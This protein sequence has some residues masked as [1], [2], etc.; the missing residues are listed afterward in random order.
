MI[1]QLLQYVYT[2]PISVY[3]WLVSVS[4]E[5][6]Q[7]CHLVKVLHPGLPPPCQRTYPK[8]WYKISI[9]GSGLLGIHMAEDKTIICYNTN[10]FKSIVYN[11]I[12]QG[13]DHQLLMADEGQRLVVQRG[14]REAMKLNRLKKAGIG[15]AVTVVV[16]AVGLSFIMAA[17]SSASISQ[18]NA[19]LQQLHDSRTIT[20]IR[21]GHLECPPTPGTTKVY[22]GFAAGTYQTNDTPT[23]NSLCLPANYRHVHYNISNS[24]YGDTKVYMAHGIEYNTFVADRT[25]RGVA[26][27]LCKTLSRSTVLMMPAT[28]RCNSTDPNDNSWTMEYNGYLMQ[29]SGAGSDYYCV[30]YNMRMF[31]DSQQNPTVATFSHVSAGN[32]GPQVSSYNPQRVLSCV[33]CT[34]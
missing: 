9:R 22:A 6:P 17:Y 23:P 30:D 21:W 18:T 31:Y 1:L 32:D 26:C 12:E 28:D 5:T 16:V 33:V 13:R 10:C 27:A 8:L 2:R 34:T 11:L 7:T 24:L 14:Q 20:Y 4:T 25:G 3:M 29:A 19:N 15:T